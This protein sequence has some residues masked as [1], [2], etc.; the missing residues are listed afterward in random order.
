M[1]C[2][3][4]GRLSL[5]LSFGTDASGRPV[6]TAIGGRIS[7]VGIGLRFISV[8]LSVQFYGAISGYVGGK[9]RYMMMRFL[10]ILSSFPFMFFVIL[11]VTLFGQNIFLNFYRYR[12]HCLALVLYRIVCGQTSA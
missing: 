10:K 11:L 3:N 5:F 9:V 2:T 6:R 1:S 12:G 4:N 8:T 7:L